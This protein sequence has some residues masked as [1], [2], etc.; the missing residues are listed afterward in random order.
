MNSTSSIACLIKNN[1]IINNLILNNNFNS[2]LISTNSFQYITSSL[3]VNRWAFSNG[4]LLNNSSA[5]GFPMPYPNGNQCVSIQFASSISQNVSL[6]SG[7]NYTLLFKAC[8]RP[9]T[10]SNSITIE[11]LK[12]NNL[13]STIVSNLT[14]PTSWTIY[15]Y[16]FTVNESNIFTF[17]IR[18]T[19]SQDRSTAF[20]NIILSPS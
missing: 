1:S 2:P 18:G 4:A 7:I 8:G 11:L 12:D 17:R 20:Q 16:N 6:T 19:S 10:T 9:L 5:W 14:T 13:F 15:T 3:T